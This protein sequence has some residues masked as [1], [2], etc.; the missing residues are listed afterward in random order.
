M[1]DRHMKGLGDL[2]VHALG[3]YHVAS[4]DQRTSTLK[5][6]TYI[7]KTEKKT[8]QFEWKDLIYL[9]ALAAWPVLNFWNSNFFWIQEYRELL[10][11]F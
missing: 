10:L 7:M 2:P 4:M 11:F 3:C 5:K 9:A 8:Y 1:W 6:E